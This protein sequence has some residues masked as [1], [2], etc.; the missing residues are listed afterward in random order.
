MVCLCS[1]YHVLQNEK[2]EIMY[3]SGNGV[4]LERRTSLHSTSW[5]R[6]CW[7]CK[8]YEILNFAGNSQVTQLLQEQHSSTTLRIRKGWRYSGKHDNMHLTL[9]YVRI[10]NPNH[11]RV[12]ELVWLGQEPATVVY[13]NMK[14]FDVIPACFKRKSKLLNDTFKDIWT[15]DR[16][17]SGRNIAVLFS[18]VSSTRTVLTGHTHFYMF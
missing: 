8:D 11:K 13:C 10:L 3:N 9:S 12:P 4:N 1:L 17:L 18:F 16:R 15:L 2:Y 14:Q 7:V 6:Q 5:L